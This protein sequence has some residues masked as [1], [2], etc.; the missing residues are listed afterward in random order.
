MPGL[1]LLSLQLLTH[2]CTF[3]MLLVPLHPCEI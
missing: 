3:A 2:G 1:H